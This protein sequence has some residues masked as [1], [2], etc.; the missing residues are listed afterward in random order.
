MHDIANELAA[1]HFAACTTTA[2]WLPG[3]LHF[4]QH[5]LSAQ[6]SQGA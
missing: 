3:G 2:D 1:A 5:Q 4:L 6:L